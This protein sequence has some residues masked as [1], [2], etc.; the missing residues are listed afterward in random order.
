MSSLR[1]VWRLGLE[2]WFSEENPFITG[3]PPLP[4]MTTPFSTKVSA[5]LICLVL[6][7]ERLL[8]HLSLSTEALLQTATGL[9]AFSKKLLSSPCF[10]P[11]LH[12]AAPLRR[13]PDWKIWLA[14]GWSRRDTTPGCRD[15]RIAPKTWCCLEMRE[16]PEH[17][18][19]PFSIK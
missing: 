12:F 5:S 4:A 3:V 18:K 11:L 2:I 19:K 17:R 6:H 13:V 16:E 7:P 8:H 10:S 14:V 9:K 1:F 15:V